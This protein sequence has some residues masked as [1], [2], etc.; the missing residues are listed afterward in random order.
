[1][2][3]R[4][5]IVTFLLFNSI[6]LCSTQA[7]QVTSENV[8][9][10]AELN[11]GLR[12]LGLCDAQ[13]Q[14]Y[15]QS[16][17][18]GRSVM[19]VARDG[20]T[21]VFTIPG[22]EGVMGV[23]APAI[24][25]LSVLDTGFSPTEG[26]FRQV[27]R[28]DGEGKVVAQHRVHVDFNPTAMAITS[29]GNTVIVG[30]RMENDARQY[31]GSVLDGTDRVL[32]SFDFPPV[33]ASERD[34][35]FGRIVGGDGVAYFVP[36]SATGPIYSITDSGNV[37][38]S[39]IAPRSGTHHHKWILG[40]GVAVEEYEMRSEA[41]PGLV[42]FDIY[43]LSSGKKLGTKMLSRP[44]GFAVACYLGEDVSV[45]A[46]SGKASPA[47]KLLTVKLEDVGDRSIGKP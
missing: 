23:V 18:R 10:G 29:S 27:L 12:H 40:Q 31:V 28:F 41:V 25:G 20:S 8:I 35:G 37:K 45:L 34:W 11:D 22:P 33:S 19:R 38:A 5:V 14:L 17:G 43:D 44:V 1:M 32:K 26:L 16:G 30:Y 13:G 47:I 7:Q 15:R 39:P 6:F 21:L 3:R 42:F 9:Q 4:C 2:A 46:H 24:P 36:D